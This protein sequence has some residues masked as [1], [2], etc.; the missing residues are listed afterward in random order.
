MGLGRARG[1]S[2]GLGTF[3]AESAGM[4]TLPSAGPTA[5]HSTR[6]AVLASLV[7]GTIVWFATYFSGWLTQGGAALVAACIAVMT[8]A[9]T[10]A[11]TRSDTR[12]ASW[13]IAAVSGVAAAVTAAVTVTGAPP[14][15]ATMVG[16]CEPFTVYAQHRWEPMGAAIRDVPL[17]EPDGKQISNRSPN[18]AIAVNGWVQS[19]TGHPENSA[20]WNADIWFHL[21][22]NS[23]WV[24]YAGVRA[25]PTSPDPL[26][27]LGDGG[28]PAPTTEEC[29]GT[30]RWPTGRPAA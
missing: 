18:Q 25:V 10:E 28:R 3:R 4:T 24:S 16:G 21:A 8:G 13:W 22:D 6:N 12:P 11:L 7:V 27:G 15:V 20:P 9:L 17:P 26:A 29:G 30:V 14:G 19:R 1:P 5:S 2:T 23:G